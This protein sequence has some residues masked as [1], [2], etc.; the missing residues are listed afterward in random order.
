MKI[1]IIEDEKNLVNL[2]QEK[3]KE[4]GFDVRATDNG[5]DLLSFIKNYQPDI[6]LLDLFLPG[7]SGFEILGELKN[8]SDLKSIPV[9]ILSNINEDKDIK[10][11]LSLGAV[12]YII[13]NNQGLDEIVEKVKIHAIRAW[14]SN[15][16]DFRS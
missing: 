12:D 6:I 16:I 10:E 3:F 2:L 11:V 4:E 15:Q 5:D 13:K 14:D 9:I 1:F 7:K 8:N